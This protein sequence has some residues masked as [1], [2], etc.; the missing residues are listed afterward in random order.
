MIS[1]CFNDTSAVKAYNMR[2]RRRASV[3]AGVIIEGA[4]ADLDVLG[5]DRAGFDSI[6][7]ESECSRVSAE[8]T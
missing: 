3:V 1:D 6:L 7:R 5:V 2:Q 8:L 4:G